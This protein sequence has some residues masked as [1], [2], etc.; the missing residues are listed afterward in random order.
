MS[1][2]FI[3]QQAINKEQMAKHVIEHSD[4]HQSLFETD[5]QRNMEMQHFLQENKTLKQTVEQLTQRLKNVEENS[6]Q[7]YNDLL[8]AIAEL[9]KRNGQPEPDSEGL[10][11]TIKESVKAN[12]ENLSDLDLK[13]Q[14]HENSVDDGHLVW[15]VNNF[16]QRTTDAIIG[17]TR[18]LH[19]APCFTSK[20]GYKFCLRLYLHGDGMGKGTHL[21]LFLV[22]MKSEYDNILE[23]P[24][25]K[26]IQFTLINQEDR[27]KDHVEKMFP[28]K[29]SSSFQ[30]PKKDMNI[31]SGCPMFMNLNRLQPEGFLKDD[32]LFVEVKID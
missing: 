18:A 14:L 30:K 16:Q 12:A 5:E 6:N 22:L 23:W 4:I 11:T 32:S 8:D 2:F 1:S 17:K 29:D 13:F 20:Y 31:A 24:F 21:S 27:S 19:S 15:K 9:S 3:S 7:Q 25:Q 10:V 28:N 26:K